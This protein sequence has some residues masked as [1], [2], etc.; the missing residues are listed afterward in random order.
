MSRST[1]SPPPERG[2]RSE[3]RPPRERSNDHPRQANAPAARV[4]EFCWRADG[5]QERAVNVALDG[6][7]QTNPHSNPLEVLCDADAV[8]SVPRL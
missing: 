2:V 1:A 6:R 8:R 3:R 5:A 4:D 7:H